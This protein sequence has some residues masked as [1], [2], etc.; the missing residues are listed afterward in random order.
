MLLSGEGTEG[1]LRL[2]VT[3]LG[4]SGTHG[5]FMSYRLELLLCARHGAG[6]ENMWEGKA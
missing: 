6:S 5:R 4:V 2:P 3:D 1:A